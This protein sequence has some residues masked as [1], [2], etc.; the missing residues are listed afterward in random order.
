MPDSHFEFPI[1]RPTPN[2]VCAVSRIES[3]KE[4]KASTQLAPKLAVQADIE[5]VLTS[6][7]LFGI[8]TMVRFVIAPSPISRL[9]PRSRIAIP[10]SQK[11][12]LDCGT[13][14]SFREFRPRDEFVRSAI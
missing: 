4:M 12:T 9:L 10:T 14:I 8:T 2:V 3:K 11:P 1:L 5:L 13:K 7:L 6:V